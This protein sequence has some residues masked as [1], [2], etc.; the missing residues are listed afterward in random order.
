LLDIDFLADLPHRG[1]EE[2]WRS[3][4]MKAT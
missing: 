3:G 1:L 4:G 2:I